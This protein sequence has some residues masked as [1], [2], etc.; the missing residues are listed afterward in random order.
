METYLNLQTS[1][2]NNTLQLVWLDLEM[3]GLDIETNTIIESAVILS[4]LQL[5]HLVEGPS[6]VIHT[7]EERLKKMD[8]WNIKTHRKSKL[9]DKCI[10]S[11]LNLKTVEKTTLAFISKHLKKGEGILAGNSV[12]QDAKF[13]S[14]YM[15]SL[16]NYLHYRIL[17]ITSLKIVL[18]SYPKKLEFKKK[19]THRALDD[20]KE[21]I[22]EYRFYRRYISI[23]DLDKIS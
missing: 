13:L 19:N 9:W 18:N 21:S 2:T 17:D 8:S 12:W 6:L 7:P 5:T 22:E 11:Q 4:D 14:K 10:E 1:T 23:I 3:T 16:Y 20:I 15:P